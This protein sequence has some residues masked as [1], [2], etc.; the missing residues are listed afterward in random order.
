[1]IESEIEELR[2]LFD[3]ETIEALKT[4]NTIKKAFIALTNGLEKRGI[5]WV[6]IIHEEERNK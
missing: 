6:E 4:M 3:N 1:M 5:N 2:G